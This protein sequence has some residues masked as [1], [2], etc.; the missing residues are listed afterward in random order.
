M[1][2]HPYYRS[3]F[4]QQTAITY[5]DPQQFSM[6]RVRVFGVLGSNGTSIPTRIKSHHSRRDRNI[7][8]FIYLNFY[9]F[10]MPTTVPSPYLPP[11]FPTFPWNH[12]SPK[13]VK[14]SMGSQQNMTHQ[15]EAEPSFSSRRAGQPSNGN[16]VPQ[17]QLIYQGYIYRNILRTR[18]C[19]ILR[20]KS[21]C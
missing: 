21:I 18:C 13:K 6:C 4:L 19:R 14:A 8:L 15:V 7:F 5:K 17:S 16:C 1:S 11:S 10:C 9:S 20:H 2:L 3:F 12:T